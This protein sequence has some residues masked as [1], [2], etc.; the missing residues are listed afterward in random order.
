MHPNPVAAASA[1]ALP[2]SESE[3]LEDD[4]VEELEDSSAD[5]VEEGRAKPAPA[6]PGASLRRLVRG[7]QRQGP[8]AA[9]STSTTRVDEELLLSSMS[10]LGLGSKPAKGPAAQPAAPPNRPA[11]IFATSSRAPTTGA[12]GITAADHRARILAAESNVISDS[13]SDSQSESDGEGDGCN[14]YFRRRRPES[15]AAAEGPASDQSYGAQGASVLS[16]GSAAAAAK[17]PEAGSLVLG[18]EGQY[19]LNAAVFQKLFP[20]Q[21]E[22]VKWLWG[23]YERGMGGILGDDMGLGKTMQCSAFLAGL[24][25]S[26]LGRRIL[27]VAPKTLLPHWLKE[28]AVCGLGS[29]SREYLGSS[30]SERSAALRSVLGPYGR[31]VLVT[32]YGMV[33]HNASSLAAGEWDMMLL[34]EGHKIKNPKMKLVAELKKLKPKVHII[35]SGTPIQNNLMEMHALFDFTTPGLLG[36]AAYFKKAYER[37]ITKGLDKDATAEERRKGADL[38]AALRVKTTEFFL[39]REK[40]DVLPETSAPSAEA[41]GGG[42]QSSGETGGGSSGAEDSGTQSGSQRGAGSQAG[43]AKVR[44][45]PRKNDLV[46]WMQLTAMQLKWYRRLLNSDSVKNVLNEKASPLAAITMLKKM[47]D[48]PA[49]ISK[50]AAKEAIQGAHK[51]AK[52][53]SR[54]RKGG[55]SVAGRGRPRSSLDDFIV[56]S[57]E[58]EEEEEEGSSDEAEE[59]SGSDSDGAGPSGR[60][61]AAL[62]G[63]LDA[64]LEAGALGDQRSLDRELLRELKEAGPDAS[65]KTAFVLALLERLHGA[66]HRTLVFS[67]SKVML[68]ILEAG[69][70]QMRLDFCRIDGD[71]ASAEERQALVSRFQNSKT[72]PVFLLTSQVGG[73]GLTLTAADRVIIVDPAWNPSIDNQSVDRAYRMGQTRDVVVYRLITC[74]TVEEKIYRKQVFKGGLSKTGTEDGIQFRYFTQTELRDLF[75]LKDEELKESK[76][77]RH[78]HDLHAHQRNATP[79]LTAHLQELTAMQGVAGIHD[80]NLLFTQ[81]PAEPAPTAAE[82]AK[83]AA[84]HDKAGLS[85]VDQLTGFMG[86]LSVRGQPF[87]G[88]GQAQGQDWELRLDFKLRAALTQARNRAAAADSQ[89]NSA[90]ETLQSAAMRKLSDG[91]AK[92]REHLAEQA[93]QAEQAKADLAQLETALRESLGLGPTGSDSDGGSAGGPAAVP[94][95]SS[96]G[97]R[98]GSGPRPSGSGGAPLC[99]GGKGASSSSYGGAAPSGGAGPGGGPTRAPGVGFPSQRPVS[100]SGAGGSGPSFQGSPPPPPPPR[101]DPGPALPARPHGPPQQAPPPPPPPALAPGTAPV[102]Q[103]AP[104]SG[105]ASAGP[106]RPTHSGGGSIGFGMGLAARRRA[107]G[108]SGGA[109]SS[110]R[111]PAAAG[112]ALDLT[113]GPEGSV[114]GR[115]PSASASFVTADSVPDDEG[116]D[117]ATSAVIDLV[118]P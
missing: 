35:I 2:S 12:G 22:G 89:H 52:D 38:A 69:V 62:D 100:S 77:Q 88:P 39:R 57:D 97:Q 106:S 94:G 112:Q 76:T 54:G 27:V 48:H 50:N 49:L 26:K 51:W 14:P 30:E 96:A 83:L 113:Q 107:A 5:E 66:G 99:P 104:S 36:D 84:L 19:V 4:D 23:L 7:D 79:E 44:G 73:L 6:T 110:G 45:L 105:T 9:A 10:K 72:I 78:L 16:S 13:G 11:S 15:P 25:G 8:G 71:V 67:Q 33:Q 75:T 40:K 102:P 58:D 101:A 108:S 64:E 114:G 28:L 87:P 95:G 86:N 24:L 20:H 74:G 1:Q 55:R 43:G 29:V 68:S 93:R 46:V 37:P 61:P 42:R 53:T 109:G 115:A 41:S 98:E 70:K 82:G 59:A 117:E 17:A 92:I 85:A 47:C 118:T 116:G 18:K 65:C 32:T 91:G 60:R 63:A 31:G 111:P 81:R 3:D 80:H 34:D 90:V 103:P 21:I 56:D